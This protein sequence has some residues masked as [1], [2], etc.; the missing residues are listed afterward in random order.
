MFKKNRLHFRLEGKE[1]KRKEK[2][3]YFILDMTSK[4][5]EWRH[6]QRVR[7]LL[8]RNIFSNAASINSINNKFVKNCT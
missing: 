7:D 4:T 3:F 5:T 8:D 2:K 1:K 6:R